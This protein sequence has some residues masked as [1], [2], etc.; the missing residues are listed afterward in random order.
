MAVIFILRVVIQCK[1]F[2]L[3]FYLK[4]FQVKFLL[5]SFE[6]N[7]WMAS[8]PLAQSSIKQMLCFLVLDHLDK[9]PS[10]L[11]IH[12]SRKSEQLTTI[13]SHLIS[14]MRFLLNFFLQ[15]FQ[16]TN[17]NQ[18]RNYK[19]NVASLDSVIYYL[20]FKYRP[21]GVVFFG[22]MLNPYI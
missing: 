3:S 10:F 2:A 4:K 6:L 11:Q 9:F 15:N 18:L 1:H 20:F 12:S 13:C 5:I 14:P 16:E 7:S 17:E 19:E 22:R 21:A 8:Y